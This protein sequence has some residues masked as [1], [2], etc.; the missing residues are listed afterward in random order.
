MKNGIGGETR[1]FHLR[2]AP[3][4]D[5]SGRTKGNRNPRRRD[6]LREF[7]AIW[8]MGCDGSAKPVGFGQPGRR[9]L[10]EYL[11]ARAWADCDWRLFGR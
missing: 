6:F 5:Y 8:T 3:G 4:E 9:I 10:R 1:L 11:G 7:D 2:R